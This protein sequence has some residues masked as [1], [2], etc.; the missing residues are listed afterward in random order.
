MNHW[1]HGMFTALVTPFEGGRVDH[2]SLERLVAWQIAQGTDGLVVCSAAGEFPTLTPEE[3]RDVLATVRRAAGRHFPVVAACG[4]NAT[5]ATLAEIALAERVGA[6]AILLRMPYYSRPTQAGLI[7]H[8][9]AAAQATTLEIVLDNDPDRCGVELSCETLE[10][11]SGHANIVGI[12]ER[13]G[14]LSRCDRIA[15]VRDR[16]FMRLTGAADAIPSYFLAGGCGAVTAVGNLVP[17]WLFRLGSAMRSELYGQAQMLQRRLAPVNA[18]LVREPE[19]VLIKQALSLLHP[20]VRPDCRLPL[21]PAGEDAA[22]LMEEVIEDFPRPPLA[23]ASGH[24]QA[25]GARA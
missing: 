5:A 20:G 4:T 16:R 23:A 2:A 21:T 22:R 8:A 17:H 9:A 6:S 11:L 14:D 15:R 1:L 24:R 10:Q 18:A 3:R 19:P 25:V 12:L 7:A 13:R